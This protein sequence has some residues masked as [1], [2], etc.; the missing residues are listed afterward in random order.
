[1]KESQKE[2]SKHTGKNGIKQ[3]ADHTHHATEDHHR[4]SPEPIGQFAAERSRDHSRESEQCD[5]QSF[6]LTSTQLRKESRKLR[7]DHIK[8]RE[9]QNRAYA[10]KPE[11]GSIDFGFWLSDHLKEK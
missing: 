1:M 11:L 8:T 3:T 6:V 7:Y 5:D 4:F 10:D 9:E 2:K